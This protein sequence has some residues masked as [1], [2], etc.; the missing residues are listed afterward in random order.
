MEYQE[1]F[2]I[3][4]EPRQACYEESV[5]NFPSKF[6]VK[7]LLEK[8]KFL[9]SKSP[10]GGEVDEAKKNQPCCYRAHMKELRVVMAQGELA[11]AYSPCL[12]ML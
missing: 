12:C 5:P 4:M 7:I 6:H 3:V 1:H 8:T 11:N 2:E 9:Q 10:S